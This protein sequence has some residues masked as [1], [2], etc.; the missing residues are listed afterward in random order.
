MTPEQGTKLVEALTALL[1]AALAG[2]LLFMLRA[3]LARLPDRISG[4]EPPAWSGRARPRHRDQA[5]QG[6]S[7]ARR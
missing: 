4:V 6:D 5:R 3:S 1:S 7:S 2:W